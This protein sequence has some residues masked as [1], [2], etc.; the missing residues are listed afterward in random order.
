[1]LIFFLTVQK[2]FAGEPFC[3]SESLW[4]GKLLVNEVARFYFEIVLS[5]STGTVRGGTTLCFSKILDSEKVRD[6]KGV[7]RLS[8]E[9]VLSHGTETIR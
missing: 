1:M 7:T 6:K 5:H 4:H 8:V 2:L 3:V 9:I